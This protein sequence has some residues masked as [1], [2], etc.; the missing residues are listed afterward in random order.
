MLKLKLD[1]HDQALVAA[2]QAEM[3][4]AIKAAHNP[5]AVAKRINVL[6]TGYRNKG[7]DAAIG[8]YPF[9]GV[10]EITAVSHKGS[11]ARRARNQLRTGAPTP[12]CFWGFATLRQI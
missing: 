6:A 11:F 5:V 12:A 2:T 8:T 3:L 7:R 10:C 9:K 1:D 4:R